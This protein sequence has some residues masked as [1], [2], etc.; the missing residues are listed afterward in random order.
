MHEILTYL[1]L[2]YVCIIL[3]II[4]NE[5]HGYRKPDYFKVAAILK[6][7]I[8][9]KCRSTVYQIKRKQNCR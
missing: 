8:K 9:S 7:V 2:E 3:H 5:N 4:Y 6:T 1:S